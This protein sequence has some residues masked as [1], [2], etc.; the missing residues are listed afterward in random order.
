MAVIL[1][2]HNDKDGS[3]DTYILVVTN[4]SLTGDHLVEDLHAW[5]FEFSHIHVAAEV[6]ETREH[7][8]SSSL[9]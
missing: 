6:K 3:N 7:T 8:T 9:N 2:N 5:H 1:T 4:I